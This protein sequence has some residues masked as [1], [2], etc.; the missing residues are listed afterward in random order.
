ME[1]SPIS[2]QQIYDRLVAVEGKVD[3]IDKNTK[4][5]VEGFDAVQG[6]FKVLGWISS[7]AKPILWIGGTISLIAVWWSNVNHK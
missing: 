6:A 7:A 1:T 3:T 4:A 2:H 5:L